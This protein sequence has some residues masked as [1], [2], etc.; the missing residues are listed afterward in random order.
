MMALTTV[1]VRRISQAVIK[2]AIKDITSP[3]EVTHIVAVIPRLIHISANT[4][5]LSTLIH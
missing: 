4:T 2:G 3:K 1:P 5:R